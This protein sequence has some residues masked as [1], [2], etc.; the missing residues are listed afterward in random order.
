[1]L[2]ISSRICALPP[3]LP[4]QMSITLGQ[5]A[6]SC[7]L[8]AG[9]GSSLEKR[10]LFQRSPRR[11]SNV[12]CSLGLREVN[13]L[14]RRCCWRWKVCL[15]VQKGICTLLCGCVWTCTWMGVYVCLCVCVCACMFVC[16]CVCVC[17][18]VCP[19]T[20]GWRWWNSGANYKMR[21]RKKTQV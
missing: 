18:C 3:N 14:H 21:N 17:V 15:C 5:L 1:M 2:V 12:K 20:F 19:C 9:L 8:A 11:Q 7:E 13:Q 6:L 16:A 4:E 10:D